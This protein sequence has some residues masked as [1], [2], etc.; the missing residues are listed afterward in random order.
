[1]N[2]IRGNLTNILALKQS[3]SMQ[4]DDVSDL[5]HEFGKVQAGEV[6]IKG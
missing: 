1:M 3:M 4:A 6:A 5:D 2:N